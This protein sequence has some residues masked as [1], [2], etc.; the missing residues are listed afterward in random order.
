MLRHHPRLAV[1][2]RNQELM[3]SNVRYPSDALLLGVVAVRDARADE[4]SSQEFEKRSVDKIARLT[5]RECDGR[6]LLFGSSKSA[7]LCATLLVA[8]YASAAPASQVANSSQSPRHSTGAADQT[9]GQKDLIWWLP[10]D[11]ESVVAARGP[12]PIAA[13]SDE[14]SEKDE[15]KWF[16]KEAT[17]AE[18]RARFEELPLELFYEQDLAA[19]LR[20][21][22]VAYAMQGSRHFRDPS[23]GAEVMEYE[24]CSIVIFEKDLGGLEGVIGRMPDWK[25]ASK[26]TIGRTR[27]LV[28]Q[29]E[30][31]E[32]TYFL[33]LPRPN[34]LLVANNRQYMQEVLERLAHK[35]APRALPDQLPEWRFL[36]ANARF[37]GLRH[38]DP[39][40]AEMDPTS[41]LGEDRTF[42]PGDPK[43]IGVLFALDPKNER[44]L[45]I[46]SFSGDEAKARAEASTGRSVAEP[47]DGVKYEVK[48]R[49]P[50]PGILEEIYTL[51]RTTTLDYSVLTILFALGRG[52]YF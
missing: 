50:E 1:H 40:Q 32:W 43:A 9:V 2:E 25:S 26:E 39:T 44:R 12:F 47:Q 37:W 28:M 15:Q 49:N 16:T 4:K 19:A 38:Y 42:D 30:N 3:R 45:V 22:T 17:Q 20:G 8:I 36:D 29:S 7:I 48:L 41:P 35:K 34:V 51:D 13:E 31:A 6:H 5:A 10:A 52:M 24:G 23:Y 14:T 21:Y 46:T 18:I 27:V 33:A 11:T